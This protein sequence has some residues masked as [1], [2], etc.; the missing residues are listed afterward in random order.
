M[1]GFAQDYENF[2]PGHAESVMTYYTGAEL[3]IY[4]TLA[5]GF[6]VCDHWFAAHPGPTW[7]NRWITTTGPSW[8]TPRTAILASA[9][10][11]R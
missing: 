7:P 6:G 11:R 1:S 4:D 2:F 5:K 9:S 3:T 10:C 8:R